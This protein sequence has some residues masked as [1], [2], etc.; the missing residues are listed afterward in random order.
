MSPIKTQDA[1]K[2]YLLSKKT[3]KKLAVFLYLAKQTNLN[4]SSVAKT[5]DLSNKNLSIY[6]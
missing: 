4:L 5:F 6:L 3:Q 2:K 1:I